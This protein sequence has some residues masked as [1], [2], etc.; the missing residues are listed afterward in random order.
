[1]F[2]SLFSIA[3]AITI[4]TLS[5]TTVAQ[6]K[7]QK[8]QKWTVYDLPDAPVAMT[9]ND[10]DNGFGPVCAEDSAAC[11]WMILSSKTGCG[12]G[13]E[14][15]VLI[16]ASSGS[17]SLSA[18]C[19]GTITLGNTTYHRYVISSYEDM[20]N[21]VQNSVGLIGFAIPLDS[22]AFSVLRFDLSGSK[23]ALNRFDKL[24]NNFF[25][26]FQKSSTRDKQI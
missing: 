8:F 1:M 2:K 6:T 12:K 18:N 20:Q 23:G 14:S 16:N 21:I 26:R 13:V 5:L 22:G 11:Y 17:Y 15:P 9:F 4:G 10:S 25:N 3:L 24:V 19:R 7:T